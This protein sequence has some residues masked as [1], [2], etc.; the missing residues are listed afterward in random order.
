MTRG[1]ND[2]DDEVFAVLALTF[3][4]NSGVLRQDGDA[5]FLFKVTRVHHSVCNFFVVAE[6]AGLLQHG[7]HESGLAMVDV[8]DNGDITELGIA[9]RRIAPNKLRGLKEKDTALL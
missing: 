5:L 6:N 3:S 7:V 4:A 8:C 9:H 1:V 2:V